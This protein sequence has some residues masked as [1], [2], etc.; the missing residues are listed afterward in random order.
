M[1][2]TGLAFQTMELLQAS[3]QAACRSGIK[4]RIS[5]YRGDARAGARA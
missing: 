1:R 5:E 2:P 4:Q 3:R